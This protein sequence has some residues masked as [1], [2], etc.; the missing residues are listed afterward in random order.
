MF[1]VS[2]VSSSLGVA[3][4]QVCPPRRFRVCLVCGVWG[5]LAVGLFGEGKSFVA[6]LVGVGAAAA[7]CLPAALVIMYALR[8]TVGLR[9]SRDE[10]LKGLDLSEHGME[11]YSG[12]QF[13]SSQ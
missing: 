5:T 8:L 13:F 9:V 4:G 11:A 10:E 6:Q 3:F 2:V 12:F 1:R 7:L